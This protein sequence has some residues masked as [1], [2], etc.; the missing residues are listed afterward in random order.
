MFNNTCKA[1]KF[2]LKA[3]QNNFYYLENLKS[4]SHYDYGDYKDIVFVFFNDIY[5]INGSIKFN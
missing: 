2:K 3:F 1:K 5:V 4:F